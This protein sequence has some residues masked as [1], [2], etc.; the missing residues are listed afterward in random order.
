M[1]V[2]RFFSDEIDIREV[3]TYEQVLCGFQTKGTVKR[4]VTRTAKPR[5]PFNSRRADMATARV[6]VTPAAAA[7]VYKVHEELGE[8]IS[9]QLGSSSVERELRRRISSDGVHRGH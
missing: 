2:P 9:V 6:M 7:G 4:V 1:A 3:Y 5:C 8:R